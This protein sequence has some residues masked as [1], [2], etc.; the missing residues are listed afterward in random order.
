MKYW[1]QAA[2]SGGMHSQ[3]FVRL[4]FS[5]VAQ[6]IVYLGDDQDAV[7]KSGSLRVA[8]AFCLALDYGIA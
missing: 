2:C 1:W 4:R 3:C 5:K 8:M 6:G 7:S